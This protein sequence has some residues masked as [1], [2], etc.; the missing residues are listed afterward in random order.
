M[1]YSV[2]KSSMK[3]DKDFGASH[4]IK[5][6]ILCIENSHIFLPIVEF[7]WNSKSTSRSISQDVMH[8]VIPPTTFKSQVT[9]N[10]K[11]MNVY[12]HTLSHYQV[13]TKVRQIMPHPKKH[14]GARCSK[15]G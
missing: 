13:P 4:W 14:P 15:A 7:S 5:P 8:H 3:I 1:Q 2:V 6:T 12:L 9:R 10:K 11:Y